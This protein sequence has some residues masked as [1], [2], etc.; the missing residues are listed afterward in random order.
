MVASAKPRMDAALAHF[1]S[2]LHTVRTGRA[3]AG[4]LDSIMVAYYGT[5]TP[6]KSL[7]TVTVPEAT[8]IVIQPFD[9]NTVKD[10][11]AAIRESELGFNP[12]DDGR[13]VRISVPPL[14]AERREELVKRVGKM[15]EEARIAVRQ[16]RGD[17]WDRIQKA[18][19]DGEITEDNRDWGREEIDKITAEYNKKIE[20][21]T[22]EKEAEIR[23]V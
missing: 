18:Q 22:K 14:T 15:A 13:V 21:A 12:S 9:A 1:T 3:S 7:A 4:M 8:Q 10:I 23:T 16:A 19:R 17:I 11:S 5:P 6:L 2:E 20:A